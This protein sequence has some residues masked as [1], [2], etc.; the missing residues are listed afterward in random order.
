M[1]ERIPSP[2]SS[3][4]CLAKKATAQVLHCDVVNQWL[5]NL[6]ESHHSE[7]QHVARPLSLPA[8]TTCVCERDVP[9]HTHKLAH[10]C[11]SLSVYVH[12]R[13]PMGPQGNTECL[14]P[15]QRSFL[16]QGLSLSLAF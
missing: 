8:P 14:P 10:L 2:H 13:S 4:L 3:P 11:V 6:L 15:S 16:M 9:V 12:W 7:T 5:Q 1:E